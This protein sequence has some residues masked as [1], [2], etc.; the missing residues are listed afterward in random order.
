MYGSGAW[1]GTVR[2]ITVP[3]RQGMPE[4]RHQ[5]STVFCAAARGT[6]TADSC[7]PL[8]GS[9]AL[10]GLLVLQLVFAL[11]F[12]LRNKWRNYDSI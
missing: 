7:V 6:T 11:S 9:G 8:S 12:P 3:A 10:A 5:A 1:T 4:A 2:I